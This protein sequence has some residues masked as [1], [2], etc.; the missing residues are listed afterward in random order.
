MVLGLLTW[1]SIVAAVTG[2][3][4]TPTLPTPTATVPS[5]PAQRTPTTPTPRRTVTR[6]T[7]PPVQPVAALRAVR[8]PSTSPITID[9]QTTDW[10]WSEVAR[11]NNRIA[12]RSTATGDIYLM[13]DDQ[14]LYLLGTITDS[15]LKAPQPNNPVG[16]WRGDSVILELGPDLRGVPASALARPTDAYYMFGLPGNSAGPTVGIIGPN[17]Q[18]TS[19]DKPARDSSSLQVAFGAIRGGYVLEARIPWQATGLNG[20]RSGAVFA[21]NVNVSERTGASYDNLGMMSTNPQRTVG[22]R[23]HPAYWQQLELLA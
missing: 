14:A 12:G 8:V 9:G 23:A 22:V 11:A 10:Q 4:S 19:F 15:S 20:V 7:L 17:A 1:P 16:V 18:G 13:W 5:S 21:A 6:P 2:S 3:A